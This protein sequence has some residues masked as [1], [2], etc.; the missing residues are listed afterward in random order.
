MVARIVNK[1]LL[2]V[3]ALIL[4]TSCDKGNGFNKDELRYDTVCLKV[5]GVSVFKYEPKTCQMAF[6]R[7]R[8]QFRCGT[9]TMSDYFIVDLDSV[10][11]EEKQTVSGSLEWTT[12]DD[13]VTMGGLSFSVEGISP[14]GTVWLWC[15]KQKI[16]AV[17]RLL[18]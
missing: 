1:I 3:A 10:P 11:S 16:T 9:D 5:K 13:V 14:D 15:A 17:I 12:V 7:G 18:N 2:L 6:N 4:T 8:A